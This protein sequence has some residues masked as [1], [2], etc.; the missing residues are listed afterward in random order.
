MHLDSLTGQVELSALVEHQVAVSADQNLEFVNKAFQHHPHEYVAV[1]EGEHF[2]GMIS[3]GQVGF[4]MGN[5]FGFTLYS[6]HEV[7]NHLLPAGLTAHPEID[8]LELLQQ[9]LSR[10]GE[11]FYQDVPLVGSDGRFLGVIPVPNLVRAQSA[12]VRNQSMLADFRLQALQAANHDLFRSVNQL[13]QSQARYETLLQHGP[14][15]VVLLSGMGE[16]LDSNLRFLELLGGESGQTQMPKRITELMPARHGERFLDLLQDCHIAPSEQKPKAFEME[17]CLPVMGNRLF[18]FHTSL[19]RETGQI[20]TILQDLTDQRLVERRMALDDKAALIESVVGGIAHELNNKLSPVLGFSDL[21]MSHLQQSGGSR[22]LQSYCHSIVDSAQ[23]SVRI[24]KQL[25]QLS[26]PA[27]MEKRRTNLKNLMEE[28]AS[29]LRFRVKAS[30]AHLTITAPE[31][32]CEIMVDSSQIKQV[33]INLLINAIDAVEHSE[34][35]LVRLSALI[36]EGHV[37]LHV[38]DTGHGIAPD[39]LNRIFDPFFTT[40]A[41]ERGTGLGL[42]VC[43]GIIRQ[44]GGEITVGSNPGQGTVFRVV[45]PLL[46][47]T[48]P[49]PAVAERP[50]SHEERMWQ[51]HPKEIASHAIRNVLVVDDE[52]YI[53]NLVQE[54]LRHRLG[55]RV[56]SLHDVR[57]AIK[58]LEQQEF[59]LLITDLRMPNLDG[60]TLIS[61]VRD[62]CPSMKNKVLVITGDS[63]SHSSDHELQSLGVPTLMKPFTPDQLVS[64][65]WNLMSA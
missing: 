62:S 51:S 30:Q 2:V 21:I 16:I 31:V 1:T 12:L 44:H 64:H 20:C 5:R 19:V 4:L 56:E 32:P 36:E 43:L 61:W 14:L 10:V 47:A 39:R 50:S 57:Q 24:I 29:I 58:R 35:R 26:R 33:L 7:R 65:C 3:R 40:K 53:T 11:A 25:L 15:A 23:E 13:R 46:P 52:E 27:T 45:L 60:F 41:A 8:V 18:S 34:Q 59:D 54:L 17:L 48:Q 49:E 63:G 22:L 42:S 28:A 9:A 6:R 37:C 38:E 55:W